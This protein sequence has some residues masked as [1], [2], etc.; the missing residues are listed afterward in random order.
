MPNRSPDVIHLPTS[1][2]PARGY[3]WEPFVAGNFKAKKHGAHSDRIITPIAAALANQLMTDLPYLQDPTYR[4]A[5]L[6]Y[7]RTVARVEVLEQWLDENGEV[8]AEGKVAPAATYL[9]RVRAHAA[10]MASRLGLDPLSRAR[11][12]KD[13]TAA[14]LDVAQIMA[15]IARAAAIERG[16]GA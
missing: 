12:G 2:G 1:Q 3:S 9:L 8:D 16:E 15:E 11:L 5:L 10:Q 13:T 4:E 14:K 6:D 7:A